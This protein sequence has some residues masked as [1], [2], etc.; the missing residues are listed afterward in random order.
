MTSL[1]INY[2]KI[3]PVGYKFIAAD[4]GSET[5]KKLQCLTAAI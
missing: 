5:I 3:L 1:I 2:N 4:I